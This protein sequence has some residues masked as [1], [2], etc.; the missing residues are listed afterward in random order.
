M[1]GVAVVAAEEEESGRMA[2]GEARKTEQEKERE[3]E[4]EEERELER[5]TLRRG[6]YRRGSGAVRTVHLDLTSLASPMNEAAAA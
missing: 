4:R 3:E 5:A 6:S 1:G 2:K